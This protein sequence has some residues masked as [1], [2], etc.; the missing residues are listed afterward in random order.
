MNEGSNRS[1]PR[2]P[3]YDPNGKR[4]LQSARCREGVRQLL[5]QV[6]YW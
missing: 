5:Q 2:P 6:V 4:T 3:P 1:G